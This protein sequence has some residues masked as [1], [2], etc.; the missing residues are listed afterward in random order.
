MYKRTKNDPRL[1]KDRKPRGHGFSRRIKEIFVR[2]GTNPWKVNLTKKSVPWAWILSLILLI[3]VPLTVIMSVDNGLM[4]LPDLYKYHFLS[5]EILSERMVAT[6]ETKVAQLMSDY[7]VHKT[8]RFQM[9]EDLEYMPA[10]VFTKSDGL[11]MKSLRTLLDAQA[12]VGILML[13]ISILIIIFIIRQKERDLLL[14]S[15][16]Y[17]LPVF[18]LMK[19]FEVAIMMFGP[20]RNRVFGIPTAGSAGETDLIP[21]LL[22]GPFFRLLAIA[23]VAG[24]LVLLGVL[25]Y[26]ILN[27][28]GRK[29]TFRR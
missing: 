21:A 17:S 11:M 22:D 13:L 6:D 7:L 29:T 2:R 27:L 28:S 24:S 5:N 10:N 25:Y 23:E 14:R 12:V 9:K 4:R 15:F 1:T 26:V 20:M 19:I 8:D 16:Y 18:A 3:S